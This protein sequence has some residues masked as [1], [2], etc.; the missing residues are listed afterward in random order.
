MKVAILSAGPSLVQTFDPD[1]GH[2]LRIGVN[3]AAGSFHCDWWS[4]GDGQTFREHEPIGLPVVFTM[5]RHDGQL[6]ADCNVGERFARH[7]VVGWN[8]CRDAL[9]GRGLPGCWDNWSIT[10]ALALAVWQGAKHVDVYGH[11]MRGIVDVA[12]RRLD[13]RAENWKRVGKDW[14]MV[15]GWAREQGLTLKHH[16]G[17]TLCT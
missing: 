16:Q 5:D 12:G 9:A 10:A 7:R 13:K 17:I 6:R 1:A 4:C 2:D 14:L 11:D 15:S 3:R 8:E